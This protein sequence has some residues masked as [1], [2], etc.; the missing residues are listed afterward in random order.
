M[1]SNT[2][3]GSSYNRAEAEEYISRQFLAQNRTCNEFYQMIDASTGMFVRSN[4]ELRHADNIKANPQASSAALQGTNI[5]PEVPNVAP[6]GTFRMSQVPNATPSSTY[7]IQQAQNLAHP[8]T[9]HMQQAQNAA[10]SRTRHMPQAPNT[11]I[12]GANTLPQ[13]QNV[14]HPRTHHMQQAPNAALQGTNTMPQ[15]SN[16]A[17]AGTNHMQQ[18]QTAAPPDN[19]P[20]V[21][22]SMGMVAGPSLQSYGPQYMFQHWQN[23][24]GYTP[25][26]NEHDPIQQVTNMAPTGTYPTQQVQNGG[27]P[28]TYHVANIPMGMVLDPSNQP[29]DQQYLPGYL[30]N[31][32]QITPPYAENNLAANPL[33]T[34]TAPQYQQFPNTAPQHQETPQ[35]QGTPQYQFP[36]LNAHIIYDQR[37]LHHG[38]SHYATSSDEF[39]VRPT[40]VESFLT[41]MFPASC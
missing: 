18:A 11:V 3:Y 7:H 5:I 25:L 34:S 40:Q 20:M 39:V 9:Q 35:Y 31:N 12:Q 8:R 14:I 37:V 24:N 2:G 15:F 17:P 36:A 21:T 28:G 29:Y 32:N 6:A 13:V 41:G 38:A 23:N 33:N 19:Y 16:V 26:Q 27:H 22:P 30:P 1:S 4:P 10:L